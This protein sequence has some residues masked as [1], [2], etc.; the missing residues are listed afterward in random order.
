MT[1]LDFLINLTNDGW[2]GDS[3][4][5]MAAHVTRVFRCVENRAPPARMLHT[6]ITLARLTNGYGR[7]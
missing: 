1:N 3:L 2:F 4:R 6:R 5:A 7:R